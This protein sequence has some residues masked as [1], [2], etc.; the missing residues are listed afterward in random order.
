[1]VVRHHAFYMLSHRKGNVKVLDIIQSVPPFFCLRALPPAGP[2]GRKMVLSAN[3]FR[4]CRD[5]Y[6]QPIST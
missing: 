1:M 3:V 5:E 6:C 4:T 2:A